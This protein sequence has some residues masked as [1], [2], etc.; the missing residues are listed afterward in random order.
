MTLADFPTRSLIPDSEAKMKKCLT[1]QEILDSTWG[2]KFH[3]AL[4]NGLRCAFLHGNCLYEGFD[5]LHESWQVSFVLND[6]RPGD[7]LPLH[8]LKR[9]M[10]ADNLKFGFFLSERFVQENQADYPLEFLHISRRNAPLFGK[11]PLEDFTP[12]DFALRTECKRELKSRKLHLLGE[13]TK[14]Q[15]GISPMDF[16]IEL[17]SEILPILY[18]IYFVRKKR[19]PENRDDVFEEFPVFRIEEPALDF[20]QNVERAD[21]CLSAMDQLISSL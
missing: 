14:V 6:V 13:W 21:S 11:A 19:Y 4:G 10:A 9:K 12:D 2:E 8:G 20:K 5:A 15:S 17:N 16:F 18:G 1:L 3:E 7:L